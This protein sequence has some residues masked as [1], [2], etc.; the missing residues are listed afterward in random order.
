[1]LLPAMA[2]SEIPLQQTTNSECLV[3]S[4]KGSFAREEHSHQ[5][6]TKTALRRPRLPPSPMHLVTITVLQ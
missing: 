3:T 1:M 4:K 6:D 2:E 5:G